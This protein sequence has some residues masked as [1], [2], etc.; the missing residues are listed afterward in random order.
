[1]SS[2]TKKILGLGV[3]SVALLSLVNTAAILQILPSDAMNQSARA[4]NSVRGGVVGSSV[5]RTNLSQS[6]SMA[7]LQSSCNNSQGAESGR[8]AQIVTPENYNQFSVGDTMNIRIVI[9][10]IIGADADRE[11]GLFTRNIETN[12]VSHLVPYTTNAN[13]L[14]LGSISNQYAPL[15]IWQI[16]NVDVGAPGFYQIEFH[17]H[18]DTVGDPYSASWN[19][20]SAVSNYSVGGTV[21]SMSNGVC[22]ME[23]LY[24]FT[25]T[26]LS[27]GGTSN[28]LIK[29]THPNISNCGWA[30]LEGEAGNITSTN[31]SGFN[32]SILSAV[33]VGTWLY[34][35]MNGLPTYW[36]AQIEIPLATPPGNYSL[37]LSD[38]NQADFPEGVTTQFVLP[39]TVQ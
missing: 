36:L 7:E 26:I 20:A 18:V 39:I 10:D 1:M 30:V 24:P 4:I 32:T 22:N 37:L 34:D 6:A 31:I 28:V 12:T 17:L 3:A 19:G 38:N 21:E 25:E 27:A 15:K 23:V 33:N 14:S 29:V 16:P 13:T 5:D 11:Y 2:Y 8:W 9:C 35:I